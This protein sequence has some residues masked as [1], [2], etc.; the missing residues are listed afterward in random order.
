LGNEHWRDSRQPRSVLIT[1][2]RRNSRIGTRPRFPS[3]S[4]IFP[5]YAPRFT[6]FPAPQQFVRAFELPNPRSA[7]CNDVRALRYYITGKRNGTWFRI[8]KAWLEFFAG[9]PGRSWERI[10]GGTSP[11]SCACSALRRGRLRLSL[12]LLTKPGGQGGIR[13]LGN[14]SATHAFQA[15]SFDHSDTCPCGEAARSLGA[16]QAL[17]QPDSPTTCSDSPCTE[18]LP[19]DPYPNPAHQQCDT[20]RKQSA[21]VCPDARQI[22]APHFFNRPSFLPLKSSQPI[23]FLLFRNSPPLSGT[24][25]AKGHSA[26]R[27]FTSRTSP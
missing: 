20:T 11:A 9:L 18:P 22:V 13:T 26:T 3:T 6:T 16:C 5:A 4:L 27:G 15:C 19:K 14:I 1:R 21:P 24:V 12:R 8:A 10:G 25:L 7:Q 17:W 2:R 23:D